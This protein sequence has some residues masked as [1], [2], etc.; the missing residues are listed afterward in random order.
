MSLLDG[1]GPRTIRGSIA[2]DL[3]GD[4]RKTNYRERIAEEFGYSSKSKIKRR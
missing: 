1:R 2:R 3:T 4:G